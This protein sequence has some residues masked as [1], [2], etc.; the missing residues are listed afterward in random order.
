MNIST[1]GKPP[2]ILG[3]MVSF[4]T[5]RDGIKEGEVKSIMPLKKTVDI[6]CEGERWLNVPLDQ[7]IETQ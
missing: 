4:K 3:K 5:P 6:Q 7:I 1:N 2:E